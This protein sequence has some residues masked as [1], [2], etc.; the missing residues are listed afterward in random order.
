MVLKA[1]TKLVGNVPFLEVYILT[2]VASQGQ[3]NTS[4]MTSAQALDTA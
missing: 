1:G 2:L 4:A 3:S